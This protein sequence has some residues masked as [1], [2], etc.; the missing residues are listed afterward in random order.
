MRGEKLLWQIDFMSF[1][2]FKYFLFSKHAYSLL[3]HLIISPGGY[4]MNCNFT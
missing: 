2:S 4:V 1:H 3:S